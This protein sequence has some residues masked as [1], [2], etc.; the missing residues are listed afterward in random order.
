VRFGRHTALTDAEIGDLERRASREEQMNEERDEERKG[1]VHSCLSVSPCACLLICF[2]FYLFACLSISL[3]VVLYFPLPALFFLSC[4][5][6]VSCEWQKD[7]EVD[8]EHKEEVNLTLLST[9]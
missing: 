7:E 3:P 9:P 8:K 4:P 6:S 2:F 5:S 1:E